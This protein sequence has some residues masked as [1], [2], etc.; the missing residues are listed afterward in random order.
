MNE[1]NN[2]LNG[3][4]SPDPSLG[5][6]G[7]GT[8]LVTGGTGFIGGRLVEK[9]ILEHGATV[10][11]VVRD[12]RRAIR[13]RR[14]NVELVQADLTDVDALKKAAESCDYIFHCAFG[15]TGSLEEQR[16]ATVEGTRAV[17]EA[18]RHAQVKRLVHLSTLSVYGSLNCETLDETAPRRATGDAYGDTKLEAEELV[19]QAHREHKLPTTI[20]QPTV[21]YGPFGGWWTAGQIARLKAGRFALPETEGVCNPVYVDDVVSAMLLSATQDE[22]VGQTFLVSGPET[23]SWREYYGAIERMVGKQSI[24]TLPVEEIR[25]R[26]KVPRK[27]RTIFGWLFQVLRDRPDVRQRL[28]NSPILG[29]PYRIASKLTPRKLLNGV[30]RLVLGKHFAGAPSD[31]KAPSGPQDAIA[32]G[33][34][35]APDTRPIAVPDAASLPQFTSTTRVLIDKARTHLGY[36]PQ[37]D[38]ARGMS[39]TEQWARWARL[40]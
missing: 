39:L 32:K 27:P 36:N 28:V 17:I 22:A 5:G 23:V 10:R 8:V 2:T 34:A 30:K 6:K 26:Q 14:F 38:L 33:A 11:A 9:L 19:L 31:A 40:T 1:R 4:P 20:L 35:Q 18:A 13:L 7:I 25:Q 37:Y 3:R 21:V 12:F 29:L 16:H 24:V 15:G